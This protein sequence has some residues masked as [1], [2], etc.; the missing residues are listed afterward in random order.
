[1]CNSDDECLLCFSNRASQ[2][3]LKTCGAFSFHFSSGKAFKLSILFPTTLAVTHSAFGKSGE[4]SKGFRG[5]VNCLRHDWEK[6]AC[7]VANKCK[8]VFFKRIFYFGNNL[9]DHNK[10]WN[11]KTFARFEESKFRFL[12]LTKKLFSRRA[13]IKRPVENVTKFMQIIQ[14]GKAKEISTK[15][16]RA[17]KMLQSYF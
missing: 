10:N 11:R 17:L 7:D 2:I 12:F 15:T 8:K 3:H 16:W 9:I 5:E 4:M 13:T 14:T 6:V 1:M